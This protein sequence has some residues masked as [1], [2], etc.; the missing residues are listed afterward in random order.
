MGRDLF[1]VFD[2]ETASP[3]YWR[4]VAL[5]DFDLGTTWTPA[6]GRAEP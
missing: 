5:P 3:T 4:M 2:V 6:T 1:T